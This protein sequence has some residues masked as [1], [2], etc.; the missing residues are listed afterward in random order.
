MDQVTKAGISVVGGF[1]GFCASISFVAVLPFTDSNIVEMLKR[2]TS[3]ACVVD[4]GGLEDVFMTGIF[5]VLV[6][7]VAAVVVA[8]AVVVL[9]VG[10][11]VVFVFWVV[12][13]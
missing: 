9:I 4:S 13:A 7:V 3:F 10:A 11:G 2:G 6:V 5:S 8:F 12:T 1:S